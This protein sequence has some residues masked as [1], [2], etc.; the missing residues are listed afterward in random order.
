MNSFVAP[1][2]AYG[3]NNVQELCYERAYVVLPPL[4][5]WLRVAS[6]HAEYRH[7]ALIDKDDIMQAARL[8]LPGV[9]YPSRLELE[10]E[11]PSKKN[12][13]PEKANQSSQQ[14]PDNTISTLN[15]NLVSVGFILMPINLS[16]AIVTGLIGHDSSANNVLIILFYQVVDD[17]EYGRRATLALAFRLMLAGRTELLIQSISLLPPS[18]RYDT[19]N[20]AGLTALMIAAVRNDEVALQVLL[21]AGADANIEVPAI[22]TPGCLAIHPETQHWT[23]VTFAAC[24]GNYQVVRI[25]LERGAHV[26]G[27]A[28]LGDDKCT[29]TPLQ[30]A[31][32]SGSVEIV[33]LLLSHGANA[34][35]STQL[36][37]S[38]SFS[39]TAQRGSYSAISV[40]A[41][42]DQRPCLRKLLSHPLAP[43]SRE[44]LSLE[45]MLAEGDSST[46]SAMDRPNDVPAKLSKTQIKCLQEAMYHSAEN[47]HLRKKCFSCF[48]V[49][50]TIVQLF[51]ISNFHII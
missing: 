25:L 40:A 41:A 27:G 38:L 37:D 22:G 19:V 20:Q 23:A 49:A 44:V 7:S 16:L 51:F 3:E 8:L 15:N 35:L 11:L 1:G 46:R 42:H 4:I 2:N 34:F 17:S 26:E 48:P 10:E 13:I 31:S 29:L 12:L 39:G 47:N 30:L 14:M 50:I 33:S 5:E 6:A 36:K 21:D 45:E 18:T 9:D 24:R 32:S 43:A 28:R